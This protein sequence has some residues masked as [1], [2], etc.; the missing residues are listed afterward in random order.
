MPHAPKEDF[1]KKSNFKFFQKGGLRGS[2][3]ENFE[4]IFPKS[5]WASKI[6]YKTCATLPKS[7]NLFFDIHT[8]THRI[9]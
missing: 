5:K 4:K 7:R 3:N 8:H 9:L 6:G 1:Q 2:N